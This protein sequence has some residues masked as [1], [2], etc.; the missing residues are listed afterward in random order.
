MACDDGNINQI[1]FDDH[2]AV[3][4]FMYIGEGVA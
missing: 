4:F 1:S 2:L 3:C